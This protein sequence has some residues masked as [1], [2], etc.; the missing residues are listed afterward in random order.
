MYVATYTGLQSFYIRHWLFTYTWRL[1]ISFGVALVSVNVAEIGLW[2]NMAAALRAGSQLKVHFLN[3]TNARMMRCV[4]FQTGPTDQMLESRIKQ[5][6]NYKQK[7][8]GR[9]VIL[10]LVRQSEG[11]KTTNP[12]QFL[13]GYRTSKST[14]G[15]C[16]CWCLSYFN[17]WS[18]RK[19]VGI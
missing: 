14:I 5:S 17:I 6:R 7:L 19:T 18:S 11:K 16:S 2:H 4:N 13:P 3:W 9:N 12:S 1:L 15:F 8:C 10:L